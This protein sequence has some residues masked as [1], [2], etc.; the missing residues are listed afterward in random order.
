MSTTTV[1]SSPGSPAIAEE[2]AATPALSVVLVTPGGYDEI[3]TTLRHLVAQTIA[4]RIEL[5]IVA[6]RPERV[7]LPADVVAAFMSLRF[8]E[9]P[10]LHS[11]ARAK[12]FA[13]P[14]AK[15]EFIVFAEDHSFPEPGWAEALVDAHARGFGG[16]APEMKNGNPDSGLSWVAMFLHFGGNVVPDSGFETDYP[17]ASHNMSYRRDALLAL[18]GDLGRR[19]LAEVFLHDALRA[20]G[21]RLWVE[22]AAATRHV[23]IS[24]MSALLRHAWFGGRL[25]GGLRCSFD[26]WSMG[27]RIVYAGGSPLVPLIRMRRAIRE[28]RRA[29]HADRMLPGSLLPMLA[30]LVVHAAGEAT[31]YLLGVGGSEPQYSKM[32]VGRDRF[33]PAA[34]R[35]LWA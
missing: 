18:G 15:A 13:V 30:I 3:R 32:E 2:R 27:R 33:V 20:Q 21:L 9:V 12:A 6:T 34:D 5:L 16:V 11:L 17:A 7:Q 14:H 1:S 24:T 31:G 19:M 10:D 8:V 23:N 25:Y 22:P 29:G 26:G 28:I 4:P 35:T